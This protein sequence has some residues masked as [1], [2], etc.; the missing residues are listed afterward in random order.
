MPAIYLQT[1]DG[2][3]IA[4][5]EEA[6]ELSVV[7][8]LALEIWA[9]NHCPQAA[10]TEDDFDNMCT[11]SGS[12]S[13]RTP[14]QIMDDDDDDDEEEEEEYD[15][16]STC[17]CC[18]GAAGNPDNVTAEYKESREYDGGRLREPLIEVSCDLD[19]TVSVLEDDDVNGNDD[20]SSSRTPSTCPSLD[21]AKSP[22]LRGQR[23][24]PRRRGG[25]KLNTF[26]GNNAIASLAF[27]E[28]GKEMREFIL[29]AP[30]IAADRID[31]EDS[32]TPST[33]EDE[34]VEKTP[35]NVINEEQRCV[36]LDAPPIPNSNP[37]SAYAYPISAKTSAAPPPPIPPKTTTANLGS[38]CETDRDNREGCLEPES[39]NNERKV[40]VNRRDSST[41]YIE[42]PPATEGEEH[43][44]VAERTAST[45]FISPI[46]TLFSPRSL[47]NEEFLSPS[48]YHHRTPCMIGDEEEKLLLPDGPFLLLLEDTATSNKSKDS[49]S[50]GSGAS[51]KNY[52]N[53]IGTPGSVEPSPR[54]SPPTHRLTENT[55]NNVRPRSIVQGSSVA[56]SNHTAAAATGG[57]PSTE[58]F[59][60]GH[61]QCF[62]IS[63]EEIVIELHKSLLSANNRTQIDEKEVHNSS[64]TLPP[65]SQNQL[66]R[67]QSR[68]ACSVTTTPLSTME[69]TSS[70]RSQTE[71]VKLVPAPAAASPD[72]LGNDS[73]YVSSPILSEAL[74]LCVAYLRYFAND[75]EPME[76]LRPTHIPEPLSAPLLRFLSPWERGFLYREILGQTEDEMAMALEIL[77]IAPTISYIYAAPLLSQPSIRAALTVKVPASNRVKLLAGVIRAAGMLKISSLENMCLAWCADFIIRASYASMDC[78]GAAALVRE[79][80]SVRNDWTKKEVDC[81]KLENEWPGNEEE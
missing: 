17:T 55:T 12:D 48:G 69:Q 22:P 78:F 65:P 29:A 61:L 37:P 13:E 38:A 5:P 54:S 19:R 66:A 56:S 49:V 52:N 25:P 50:P 47:T 57:G 80:F 24:T 26:D 36:S 21:S 16:P 41:V 51:N 46:P 8:R 60:S 18:H 76:R 39:R 44:G 68:S 45:D 64:V 72:S 31:K 71:P 11:N 6:G 62:I 23:K 15:Y 3:R 32:A 58:G 63:E 4:V 27:S 74:G 30:A 81:L 2:T 7:V 34:E 10:L 33:L 73:A 28:N 42:P 1:S 70:T 43:E 59:S 53:S 40:V 35:N 14:D 20:R 77:R 79:C 67:R 9:E 75:A